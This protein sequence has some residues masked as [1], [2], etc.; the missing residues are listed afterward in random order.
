M[1][2]R[3]IWVTDVDKLIVILLMEAD[4]NFEN[5]LYFGER[6]TASVEE[7]HVMPDNMFGSREDNSSI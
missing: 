7:H 6:L 1:L 2:E 4:F 5:H 3:E